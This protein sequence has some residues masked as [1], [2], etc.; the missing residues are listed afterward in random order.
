MST[1]LLVSEQRMK[2]W[3]NLDNNIRIDILTPSILQAQDLYIQDTLGTP[4][5]N[6]LKAQIVANTLTANESTFLKDYIG[7]CLMQYALYM[8]MPALKYKMVEKGILNGVSEET[9]P[10]TL[11]EM[12]WLQQNTLNTAEFYNKRML[13]FLQ[14]NP[15]MFPLYKDPTVN[16]GMRPNRDTPFFAGLQ[17]NVPINRNDLY[18]YADCD[19]DGNPDCGGC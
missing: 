6:Q 15:N 3:T 10:T 14:N 19:C 8:L 11:D 12:K 5:Y 4:F 16:D 18:I 17:T 9:Q 7:P 13:E 2:N 1:V